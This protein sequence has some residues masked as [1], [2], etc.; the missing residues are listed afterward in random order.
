MSICIDACAAQDTI[1]VTTRASVYEL[2]VLRDD[3]GNVLVRGGSRFTE[4]RQ[5]QFVGSIADDGSLNVAT[6]DIGR[7]M[8]FDLS[9]RFVIT[10]PVQSIS[11]HG[12]SSCRDSELRE[13]AR[14]A[15]QESRHAIGA[16]DRPAVTPE[17]LDSHA[18]H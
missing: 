8:I 5:V 7:R 6:I 16:V 14:A 2:V 12:A 10:S 17:L 3:R 18:A 11:R 15:N 9:E 13:H 1:V 4:F